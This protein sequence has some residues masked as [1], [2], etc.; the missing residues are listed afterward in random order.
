MLHS[1]F[2]FL[3]LLTA[4]PLASVIPLAAL[5]GILLVVAW[6]MAE[7]HAIAT[8]LRSSWGDAIVLLVTLLLTIFRD[9]TEGILVGFALGTVLFMHRMS[10]A[11]RVEA[12]HRW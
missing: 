6:N 5:A 11:I 8:L 9:L 1:L 12:A 7:K 4:A 10:E 3:M 2:L